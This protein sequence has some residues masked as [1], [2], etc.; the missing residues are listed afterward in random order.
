VLFFR[1]LG[2]SLEEIRGMLRHPEYERRAAL[3]AQKT[4]LREKAK[5][6]NKMARVID[7]ILFDGRGRNDMAT[8][9][10]FG[11][12]DS[13]TLDEYQKEARERWGGTDAYKESE[14]KTARY[15][16]EDWER[17]N[18][19]SGDIYTKIADLMDAGA[20]PTDARV[21]VET[22]RW[23]EHITDSFYTCTPEIFRGLAEGY[24]AD[25]RFT[26]NIDGIR[27]GLAVYLKDAMIIY[28]NSVSSNAEA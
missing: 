17:I 27:P 6:L 7:K 21:Q 28:A 11:G 9:E 3:L 16:K 4:M 10:L 15:N 14:R 12:L 20:K 23:Y 5:R 19:V 2:F 18:K 22:K 24:V 25:K 13:K 8:D 1:E 26:D